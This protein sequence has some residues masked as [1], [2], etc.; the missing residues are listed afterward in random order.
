MAAAV[1]AAIPSVGKAAPDPLIWASSTSRWVN[2]MSETSDPTS[3]ILLVAILALYWAMLGS[4][5]QLLSRWNDERAK[6]DT[7]A[8]RRDESAE[9]TSCADMSQDALRKI[10]PDFDLA[11]FLAGARRAYEAILR[12]FAESDIQ[13]LQRLVGPEVLDA[14]ERDIVGRR[15]RQEM[16]ELTFI[17]TDETKVV[18]A[19]VENGTAEIVVRYVSDVVGV[20]RSAD[21][22]VVAGDPW[23][24]VE[25]IDTWTFACQTQS[26]KRNWMLIATEG[27]QQQA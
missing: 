2:V 8:A 19:F 9:H 18:D 16:L 13:T 1:A 21:N 20:T 12:A 4:W 23:E 25:M 7:A 10:D 27:E 22:A 24:I 14:F 5:S 15:D 17:R 11:A 6:R 26:R 3:Q